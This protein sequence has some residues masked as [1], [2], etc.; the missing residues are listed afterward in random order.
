MF[1]NPFKALISK[2]IYPIPVD[3]RF[4]VYAPL[5]RECFMADTEEVCRMEKY[6]ETEI[7]NE[8]IKRQVDSILSR[9]TSS[10]TIRS[11]QRIAQIHKLTILP[12][13]ACNFSCSYCYSTQGRSGKKMEFQQAKSAIDFFIN[14]ERTSLKELWLAVLGGGEPFLTPSLTEKIIRYAV[15]RADEQAIKLGIGLTTNGSVYHQG[16]SETMIE[17]RVSLGISFEVLEDIQNF[18]RQDYGKV[19]AVIDHYSQNGVDITIKSIITPEN[20]CRLSEMVEHLHQRFPN[21]RKYKLQIVEDTVLFSDLPKMKQFYEDFT[22]HFFT[23]S[24]L[25]KKHGIDVYVLASKYI[26]TLI[27]HYCGGEFC[28]NPEGTITV[29]HRIS[30]PSEPEYEHFVYASM[31]ANGKIAINNEKFTQ[32]IAHDVTKNPKCRNCFVKWHCGGGC[33]AQASIYNES[34]LDIICNWTRDFTKQ[35][36]LNRIKE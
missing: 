9:Q 21:I 20:V 31:D 23:A 12:N 11:K 16:L 4:L 2:E 13:Y 22:A 15:Q 10:R 29:C 34:Q 30:S 36:L 24:L 32:L 35:L 18:Q 14:K 25:G 26:D 5:S 17:N 6:L 27:E 33:F 19:S 28:L 8:D 3:K 7:G 1:M